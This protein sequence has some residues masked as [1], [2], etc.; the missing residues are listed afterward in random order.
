MGT[1]LWDR[2]RFSVPSAAQGAVGRVAVVQGGGAALIIVYVPHSDKSVVDPLPAIASRCSPVI[3]SEA[4]GRVEGSFGAGGADAKH[5]ADDDRPQ[6][7]ALWIQLYRV[8]SEKAR[9]PCSRG[10]T[11]LFSR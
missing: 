10:T 8:R 2:G 9:P 1:G 7:A 5:P 6:G 3:L 4:A 11:L